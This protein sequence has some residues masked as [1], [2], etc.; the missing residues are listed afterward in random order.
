[1]PWIIMGK[2]ESVNRN[3]VGS[4]GFVETWRNMVKHGGT[5]RNTP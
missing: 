1:M 5:G 3:V 2:A 4:V